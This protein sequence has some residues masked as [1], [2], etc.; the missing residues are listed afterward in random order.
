MVSFSSIMYFT[1]HLFW[2]E[3]ETNA[4]KIQKQDGLHEERKSQLKQLLKFIEK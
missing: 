4:M 3:F 2:D 1:L